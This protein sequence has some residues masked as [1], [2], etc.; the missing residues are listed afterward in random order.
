MDLLGTL[1]KSVTSVF[2]ASTL[3]R[4]LDEELRPH[5][6]LATEENQELGFPL[7]DARRRAYGKF[8]GLEQIRETYRARRGISG[9]DQLRCDLRF[10][11]RQLSR[12]PGFALTAV[13]TLALG[14]GP[15]AAVFSISGSLAGLIVSRFDELPVR[16]V[17]SRS[18]GAWSA[19]MA[20]GIVVS[21]AS[22]LPAL[23]AASLYPSEAL[24]TE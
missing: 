17:C 10:G 1:V 12:S 9:H 21:V 8:G 19:I 23:R 20:L 18:E 11:M 4:E 6:A 3:D 14:L 2:R 15:N 16:N 22:I 7:E 5:I 24:R 13:S